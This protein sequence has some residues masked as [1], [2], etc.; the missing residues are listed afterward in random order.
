M[1]P[2][3]VPRQWL[4]ENSSPPPLILIGL[5]AMSSAYF[6]TGLF[7]SSQAFPSSYCHVY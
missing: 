5:G 7:L 6:V 4:S 3:P 1:D 2:E